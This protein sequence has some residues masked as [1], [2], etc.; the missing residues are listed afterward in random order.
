MS[1]DSIRETVGFLGVI[2]SLLFVGL[3]IRQTNVIARAQTR[4]ELTDQYREY[5][6]ALALDPELEEVR[7]PA[8][9][10][11][12]TRASILQWVR[13]RLLENVYLQFREGV[14]DETV[15][16]GYGWSGDPEFQSPEFVAWWQPRRGRFRPDFVREFERRQ[17]I[18]G[19]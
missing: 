10:G 8:L 6:M 13:L 15:L 17:G 7:S 11:D 12:D 9:A 2:A 1:T 5:W 3:Q 18:A 14:I 16:L 19:P 4:Q